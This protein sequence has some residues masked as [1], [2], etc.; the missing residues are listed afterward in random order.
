M[1]TG[2]RPTH[3]LTV[4][5]LR[6]R[7]VVQHRLQLPTHRGT[8]LRGA[9]LEAVRGRFC[10]LQGRANAPA[11]GAQPDCQVCGLVAATD[12]QGPRG[13]ELPRPYALQPASDRRMTL[14]PGDD[15]GFDLLLFGTG[16]AFFPYL[17]L[18]AQ[19]LRRLGRV[20]DPSQGHNIALADIWA[21]NDLTGHASR[22]V[23][24][25]EPTFNLPMLP[26]D[27]QHVLAYAATLPREEITVRLRTPL[28]LVA[29][30]SLLRRLHFASLFRR[31]VRRFS[32]L[33]LA[34]G[35][36]LPGLDFSPLLAQAE[37]VETVEDRTSWLD[38][39]SPSSRLGRTTPI[40]GLV[41]AVSFRG[42]LGPLLPWLVWGE[43]I[44]AGKDTTKGNGWIELTT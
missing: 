7:Y 21:V 22:L 16:I 14:D 44:G 25:A 9:L 37:R 15:L 10:I 39:E 6:F 30:G 36:G 24:R 31:I 33:S 32:D 3:G 41:G 43:L 18:A 38:V 40:G 42:D 35:G 2:D 4:H 8:A 12:A 34:Y 11:C 20:D 29:D 1:E 27:H 28:R 23:R 5:R 13:V 26:I 19:G 17:A